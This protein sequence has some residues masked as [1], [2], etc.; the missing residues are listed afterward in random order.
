MVGK[1]SSSPVYYILSASHHPDSTSTTVVRKYELKL[2]AKIMR[3]GGKLR[4]LFWEK[5]TVST[6][7]IY[8]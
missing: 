6:V 3:E 7:A 5:W 8:Y 2:L 4:L 1:D